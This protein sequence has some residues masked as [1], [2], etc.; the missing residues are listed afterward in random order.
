MIGLTGFEEAYPREISG[1]MKQRVGL[2]RALVRNPELL[3]LDEPFSSL[4]TFT[5]EVL[6]MNFSIFGQIK[7][8]N[9]TP[10]FSFRMMSERL[11]SWLIA[12]S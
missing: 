8:I 11:P 2:A 4:D 3:L 10:L 9:S 7:G 6:R 12:S 5:A 1:G